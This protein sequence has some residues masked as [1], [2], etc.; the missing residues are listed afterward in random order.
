MWSVRLLRP[1]LVVGW[2]LSGGGPALAEGF[3]VDSQVFIG[4]ETTPHS[5]NVTLFQAAHVYDFLDHPRQ[6]TIYDLARGR[7]VLVN[8]DEKVKAELSQVMLESF[9]DN[10]RRAEPQTTDPVLRFAL[11]P[12]FEEEGKAEGKE[13]DGERTY[14][15]RYI[16]Y[17]IKPLAE[18]SAGA[19]SAYRKFSDASARLNAVVNRGSLPPFPRLIVNESLAKSGD[20]PSEVHLKVSPARLAGG[21]TVLLKSQHEYRWRLLDSDLRMIVQAGEFLAS[22][23]P[24]SL[25]EYLRR[26]AEIEE[27]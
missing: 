23:A 15:S 2:L 14:S 21:R 22:A 3:R 11:D 5:T 12:R 25:A 13:Y 20:V 8:P 1:V 7:V 9:C 10:R 6:I 19:A 24:V 4:K 17:R 18:S 26:G 27:R 16:T